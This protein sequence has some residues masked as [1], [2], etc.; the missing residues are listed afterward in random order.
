MIH[1]KKGCK[2]DDKEFANE[3][4][5]RERGKLDKEWERNRIEE[6]VSRSEVGIGAKLELRKNVPWSQVGI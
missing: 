1:I 5:S 4:I 2:T 6:N 3:Q